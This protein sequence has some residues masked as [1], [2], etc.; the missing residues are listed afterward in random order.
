MLIKY[1]SL[2]ILFILISCHSIYSQNNYEGV[3]LLKDNKQ[4]NPVVGANVYWQNTSI[5]SVTNLEGEFSIPLVSSSDKLIISSVGF[6][7]DTIIIDST[8]EKRKI[9]YLNEDSTLD[10]I[11][12]K[13]LKKT[14]SVSYLSSENIINVSSEELLKA[15]CCNLSE[16]FETNP[17]IDVNF[18]DAI[19]GVKQI[20]MLGLTSP[21]ILITTENIPTIRGASQF[22]GMSLIP[23]TWVE[24]IQITKGAGSVVNGYESITGQINAELQKP[25]F[26]LPIFVNS[27][28]S[29][30]GR[31]ELNSH[32]NKSISNRLSTGFYLHYD[33]IDKENDSNNDGFLDTPLSKQYNF[34][35]RWQYTNL[36]KGIVGFLNIRY[37]EDDKQ[38]GEIHR[39]S[40]QPHIDGLFWKS[41]VL[42]KRFESSLKLGYV[43]PEINYRTIGLQ[44]SYSDHNQDSYFGLND[45]Y[46]NHKSFYSNFIYNS[47]IGDTRHKIKTGINYTSD[48]YDENISNIGYTV[49]D[50]NFST[51]FIETQINQD[52]KEKSFGAFFEYNFD[53]LDNVNLTAGIR[54]DNHNTMGTFLTPRF[55]LRY[56]PIEKSTVRLSFGR[57]KRVANIFAEN[58]NLF[59][60]SRIINFE[61]NL[62]S[63]DAWNYG[64]SFIQNFNL[65]NNKSELIFDYYYTDFKNKI[66]VDWEN[67]YEV[68]F[69]NLYGKSFASSFQTQL[70]IYFDENTDIKL[71]YKLYDVKTNYSSNSI[72]SNGIL[73]KPMTP[74]ERFFI[75]FAKNTDVNEKGSQWKFDVTFNWIGKQRFANKVPN[76]IISVAP[77]KQEYSPDFTT[78]NSQ[79]TKVFSDK[80]E[81]YF[82]VENLTNTKQKNPILMSDDPFSPGFDTTFV[83]GPIFGT[84]YYSG[85]RLKIN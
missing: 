84:M 16:S 9:F 27:Y 5:G 22:Y 26:D 69:Y 85:L 34:L 59:S 6:V 30:M 19:S 8:K 46:I 57:G 73:E 23:G 71:A 74:R 63:E 67:P 50:D 29:S 2:L 15:A 37:L 62:E 58:Q 76:H 48:M 12:V 45:Y 52:R 81:I 7:S 42:T 25:S 28:L 47:I 17:S 31:F 70:N 77:I 32:F 44:I 21:Y 43:N 3:V 4:S 35:N 68:S 36:E 66:I 64:I 33:N 10:E 53:N 72:H 80:F 14:S 65:F 38:A 18:T 55:H 54:V 20:Q 40:N 41:E 75:N 83:Y 24:S 11:I 39:N 82:G 60:T 1:K 49:S 61:D 13:S 51:I 79:L 78:I 56:T